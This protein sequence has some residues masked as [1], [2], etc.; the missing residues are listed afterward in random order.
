MSEPVRLVIW[1]LDETFWKGTLTEG[2]LTEAEHAGDIVIKLAQRGIMSSICSRNDYVSVQDLMERW[3]VWRYF[4]FPSIDWSS[5]GARVASIIEAVQ[6]RPETVLF[7][8]DNPMNLQEAKYFT[9]TLQ[10]A[11]QNFVQEMLADV[12]LRGKDDQ[13]LT[14]LATYKL[15]EEKQQAQIKAGGEVYGFLRE[16]GIT[17]EIVYDI[18]ANIDRAVELI[19][20]TNQLNFTKHRLPENPDLARATLREQ[21]SLFNVQAGL[22]RVRDNFGDY[23]LVGFYAQRKGAGY[24]DLLHYCFSCRTLGMFAEL[25]FYRELGRPAVAMT[26]EV[27]TDLHDEQI[28]VDWISYY[29]GT[30]HQGLVNAHWDDVL[31]IGGCDIQALSHYLQ[32]HARTLHSHFISVRHGMEIRTDHTTM[33]ARSGIPPTKEELYFLRLAGYQCGDFNLPN[34]TATPGLVLLSLWADAYYLLFQHRRLGHVAP[35]SP[36]ALWHHDVL[37]LDEGSLLAR[38]ASPEAMLVFHYLEA[39]AICIGLIDETTFKRNLELIVSRF[40]DSSSVVL[41]LLSER[42]CETIPGLL[43]RHKVFNQWMIEATRLRP[44]ITTVSIDPHIHDRA[45]ITGPTHFHRIVYQRLASAIIKEFPAASLSTSSVIQ[46]VNTQSL[47]VEEEDIEATLAIDPAVI[48]IF[49]QRG[50]ESVPSCFELANILHLHGHFA[51]AS[52]L[53]KRAYDLHPKAPGIYPLAQSLLYARLLCLIKDRQALEDN[54]LVSLRMLNT[55]F[56]KLVCGAQLLMNDAN[57]HS[58]IALM[59]NCYEEFHTGE[60]S[61]LIYVAGI[62]KVFSASRR[63]IE[64]YRRSAGVQSDIIP[65]NLFF[66]WDQ[67]PP[68]EIQQN[69]E[70]HSALNYFN[71]RVFNKA[72]A[73]HW[74]YETF[75]FEARAVFLNA[76]HPAEAADILRVHVIYQYGGYWLDADIRLHSVDRFEKFLPKNVEHVFLLTAG[77]V[78]HNDFFGAV[79]GSKIL[80]DCLLSL[81]RNCFLHPG[82]YIPFK[83]G[84]GIFARALNRAYY[85]AFTGAGLVPSAMV[86]DQENFDY[87]IEEFPVTYKSGAGTWHNV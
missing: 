55:Q 63:R 68:V 74:L 72:T 65:R 44:N 41:L 50:A 76:R 47:P 8:D 52:A 49:R 67:A 69:F 61:D 40:Q 25:W 60:E 31:L 3:G 23:G 46:P 18:E 35:F 9:P 57:P 79:R 5:K 11:G 78:V 29:A 38:Q 6:L 75:G 66:Y 39:N 14:R 82:L 64:N 17:V 42:A 34:L 87:V 7:L 4:I 13:A 26:G 10:V 19:N 71:I 85:N 12:R 51:Q 24:H 28:P 81:Y 43:V 59:E 62:L 30:E 77:N 16:S 2:G 83:T 84:P 73:E 70:Y 86:L 48:E 21:L 32:P 15:L 27:L 53:Y 22:L 58:A 80:S 56:Y 45:E 54:E 20:R 36:A 33:L 1:D 37:A